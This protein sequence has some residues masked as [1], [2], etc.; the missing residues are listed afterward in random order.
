MGG[1][2]GR[3]TQGAVHLLYGQPFQD[4]EAS[5]LGYI[6]VVAVAIASNA[7]PSVVVIAQIIVSAFAAVALYLL[8]RDLYGPTGG[9]AAAAIFIA[10]MDVA[11][12]AAFLLTDSLYISF[13]AFSLLAIHRARS[14][15]TAIVAVLTI[16]FTALLRPNGWMFIPIAA[17]YWILRATTGRTRAFKATSIAI[18]LVAFVVITAAVSPVKKAVDAER[19]EHWLRA[20]VVLWNSDAWLVTMPIDRVEGS[21]WTS[22]LHYGLRHPIASA[23]LALI[24]VGAE[25]YHA[26]PSFDARRNLWIFCFYLPLYILAAIGFARARHEALARLAAAVVVAHLALV[27]LT[28]ADNDGRFLLY[29]V[30]SL[31][32]FAGGGAAELLSRARAKA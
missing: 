17:V 32:L 19:P 9:L 7:Q 30:P 18:V 31:S 27:A 5:Y 10:N 2:T 8:G 23:R 11:R 13:V 24:R 26:R 1:D 21:G 28:F 12:W 3:Y 16:V 15:P 29:C 14:V 4:K 20:G 25:L 6:A 22:G